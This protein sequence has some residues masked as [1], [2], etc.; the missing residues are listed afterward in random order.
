LVGIG[1]ATGSAATTLATANTSLTT[2]ITSCTNVT[3]GT[4]ASCQAALTQATTDLGKAQT[5]VATTSS[6]VS[7]NSNNITTAANSVSTNKTMQSQVHIRGVAVT[8]YGLALS[9]GVVTNDVEWAWGI[10]PK[11]MQMRLYDATIAATS[12]TS[13]L[14]GN[15]YLA[16][17]STLNFDAG[18]SK[19]Y[20]NGWRSGIVVKN[21]IPQSFDFKNAPTAG[22][23]PVANGSTLHLNPQVRAG[24]GYESIGLFSVALDADLTRNDPAGLEDP[25]QYLAIGGEVSTSGWVQIR[26]GYRADLVNAARN[27]ASIGFGLSPRL[28][29]FKP[30]F[31]FAIT[32]SPDI[33]NNGWDAATQVGVAMKFGLNF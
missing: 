31:D 23:T 6:T 14:T 3:A 18:L 33:F 4:L 28:P 11:V 12:S 8:E 26:A 27:V 1:T 16:Y 2:A 9:H 5:T 10:T 29:S 30:H 15:D 13:N 17:Y 7:T 22:A 21:V 25:S 32:A 20:L 19:V 24:F